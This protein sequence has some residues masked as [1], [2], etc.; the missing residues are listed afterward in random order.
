MVVILDPEVDQRIINAQMIE[1]TQYNYI[2]LKDSTVFHKRNCKLCLNAKTK[3]RILGSIYYETAAKNHRPCKVCNP[4]PG[5][6]VPPKAFEKKPNTTSTSFKD[7]LDHNTDEP[8]LS[9]EDLLQASF[10]NEE[11]ASDKSFYTRQQRERVR[12][13]VVINAKLVNG[14]VVRINKDKI[15][16]WCR[17]DMHPG[18]LTKTLLGE[19]DCLRKQCRLLVH[20]NENPFW[21]ALVKKEIAKA[22]KKEAKR[23]RKAVEA[24]KASAVQ[25][26]VEEL[27][28][29]L[30]ESHSDM[31]IIRIEN[32]KPR[33]Y[34][35]YYVSDNMF[36]DGRCYSD[37][38]D[39]L[40]KTYP[41]K[42]FLFRH[43]RDVDGHFVT[44]E[45]FFSR[46]R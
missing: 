34:K 26:F 24:N 31:Y 43:I 15:V 39:Y 11:E 9:F 30:D 38:F 5:L 20:N 19:H 41:N 13:R 10:A 7:S 35:I 40:C 1:R 4:R 12:T 28:R 8:P 46:H 14:T 37:F 18:A 32:E 17:Y 23:A 45:E 3:E 27:R 33:I 6:S 2:Y 25:S 44:R 21:D 29:F 42:K 16:G 22:K 36:A